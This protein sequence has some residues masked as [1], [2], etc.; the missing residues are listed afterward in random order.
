M[1]D[2]ILCEQSAAD[3][4]TWPQIAWSEALRVEGSG[5]TMA[6]GP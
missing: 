1:R 5:A 6:L 2:I 3:H 4:T